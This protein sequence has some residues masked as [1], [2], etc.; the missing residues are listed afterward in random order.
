AYDDSDLEILQLFASVTATAIQMTLLA[1]EVLERRRVDDEL[2]LARQVI[3]QLL[4]KATPLVPGYDLYSVN[5]PVAAGG[6]DYY[7][8][9]E[10]F[11]ERLGVV[12]ADV[13]G[14]GMPAALVMASF[15]AYIHAMVLNELSIRSIFNKINK[16]LRDSTAANMFITCF[17]GVIDPAISRILY[18]NA[19]HNPPLLLSKDGTR[20]LLEASGTALGILKHV[21]YSEH[22]AEFLPGDILILYTD[23]I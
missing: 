9:I 11:D 2:A 8:Y 12:V 5:I 10:V 15:R 14:K 19:G 4:P 1:R 17:Y 16:L 21:R 13:S 23:G 20:R 3:S 6:G 7:Y 22:V 18:I